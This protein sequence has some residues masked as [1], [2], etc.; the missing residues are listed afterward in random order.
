MCSKRILGPVHCQ[1]VMW[2]ARN[3]LQATQLLKGDGVVWPEPLAIPQGWRC[4]LQMPNDHL[5]MVKSHI[6]H[7]VTLFTPNTADLKEYN[8]EKNPQSHGV[9]GLACGMNGSG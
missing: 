7:E 9:C 6:L 4:D 8:L 3:A 1:R 5:C 2:T